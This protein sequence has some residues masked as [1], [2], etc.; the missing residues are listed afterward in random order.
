MSIM[1][2]VNEAFVENLA[3]PDSLSDDC[4][5]CGKFIDNNER[6][7]VWL[8]AYWLAMHQACFLDWLARLRGDA[9]RILRYSLNAPSGSDGKS[10]A[11]DRS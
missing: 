9:E 7:W 11:G 5:H 1:V 6:P 4:F 2:S 8:G 10:G 3:R